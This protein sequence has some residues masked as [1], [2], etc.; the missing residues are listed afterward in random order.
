MTTNLLDRAD[1]EFK[2]LRKRRTALQE[3]R[4]H[5]QTD[6]IKLKDAGR[7]DEQVKKGAVKLREIDAQLRT[8]GGPYAVAKQKAHQSAV[9][10]VKE[11]A[12]YKK[13][14][15]DAAFAW[16]AAIESCQPL[17]KLTQQARCEG[18]NL[19]P[20]PPMIAA[21]AAAKGWMNTMIAAGVLEP[22]QL[23]AGLLETEGK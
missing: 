21:P 13:A 18:V 8:L 23:P 2:Q 15:L 5:L 9:K 14:V 22:G 10:R 6:V 20:L 16:A 17:V 3:E 11:S 1:T 12:V 19:P 7:S 4:A